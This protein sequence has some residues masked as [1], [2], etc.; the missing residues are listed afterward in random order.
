MKYET[1]MDEVR[2]QYGF[3]A[4]VEAYTRDDGLSWGAKLYKNSADDMPWEDNYGSVT[5]EAA[6]EVLYGAIEFTP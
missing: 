6:Y 1:L 2:R 5:K 3:D 4:A